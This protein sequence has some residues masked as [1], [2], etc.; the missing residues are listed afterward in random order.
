MVSEPLMANV[1]Q[2][3][4]LYSFVTLVKF[5]QNNFI[6][7][8]T[9]VLASIKANGLEGFINGDREHYLQPESSTRAGSSSNNES[10]SVNLEFTACMKTDQL[11]FSWMMSS[12]HQNLL[13]TV[14]D[15]T[16]SKQLWESLT[17]MYISQSQAQISNFKNPNTNY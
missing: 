8:R 7:W 5:D 14:I 9:Q 3:N 2:N 1:T 13:A 17:S 4:P 6:L 12:I 15:Y 10:R 11:L 16:T